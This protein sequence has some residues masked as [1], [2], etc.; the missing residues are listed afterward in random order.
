MTTFQGERPFQI[1]ATPPPHAPPPPAPPPRVEVR[2]DEIVIHEKVQF[3]FDKANILPVS[4]SLLDEVADVIQKN[5]RIK[6]IEVQGHASSEGDPDHNMK[7]SDARAAAVMSYLLSKGISK[8]RLV[9]K[10]YGSTVPIAD[11]STPD[12]RE[13]N[14]RVQF[15]IRDQDVTQKKVQIDPTTGKE[16]VI[17]EKHTEKAQ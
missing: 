17:A 5:Q 2:N 9:S 14:R 7:L 8:D 16:R 13:Q 1:A 12:G 6:K 10:G 11:N 3:A 15:I 4:H